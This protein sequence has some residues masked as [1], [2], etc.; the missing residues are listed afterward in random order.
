[1]LKFIIDIKNIK[2]ITMTKKERFL[3]VLKACDRP[4]TVAEWAEKVVERYPLILNQVNS[5]TN[6]L[7]TLKDLVL[8]LGQKLSKHEFEEVTILNI[9][10]YRKVE[11]IPESMRMNLMK[12]C[13]KRDAEPLMIASKIKKDIERLP[14]SD[15]Y[16]IEELNSIKE[17]LNSYFALN[18]ILHHVYGVMSEKKEGRYNADNLE[19]LTEEHAN[20]KSMEQIKFS[21]ETQKLYIKRMIDV[22]M[23]LNSDMEINLSDDVLDMLL[24]RLE[25]V[26]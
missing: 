12:Q 13:I 26:Y 14:E 9:N 19:L 1:M 7:M 16:R 10:P 3:E 22:Q 2:E 8:G 6:K 17:Q 18:F 15:K 11:Y 21:L 20:K 23:M 25:K 24:E 5:K 4:V